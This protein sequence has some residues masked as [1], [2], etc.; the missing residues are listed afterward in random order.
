[1]QTPA[2]RSCAKVSCKREEIWAADK[3]GMSCNWKWNFKK[4]KESAAEGM[5]CFENA[6]PHSPLQPIQ[7]ISKGAVRR[8]S[9][10]LP[11]QGMQGGWKELQWVRQTIKIRGM[12][13]HGYRCATCGI[14]SSFPSLT[15]STSAVVNCDNYAECFGAFLLFIFN[16]ILLHL[17][18]IQNWER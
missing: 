1:M 2:L 7:A 13:S 4:L 18:L 15:I 11:K 9:L 17:P 10:Q 8:A 5:E 16:L 6:C 3:K 14:R 12:I